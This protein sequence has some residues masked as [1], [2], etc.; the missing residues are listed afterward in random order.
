MNIRACK[1][2][3]ADFNTENQEVLI[4]KSESS[5]VLKLILVL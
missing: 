4:H 3:I 2:L 1:T 5:E